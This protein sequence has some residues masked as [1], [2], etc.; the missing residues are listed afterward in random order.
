MQPLVA[1]NSASTRW[2]RP[3]DSMATVLPGGRLLSQAPMAA[4]S[5]AMVW[6]PG[7]PLRAMTSSAL[8]TST[9]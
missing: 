4:A 3:V 6:M 9:P 1:A 5:L 2:Y 7:S 8:A